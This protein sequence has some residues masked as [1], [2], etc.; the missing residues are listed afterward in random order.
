[1]NLE[2]SLQDSQHISKLSYNNESIR[3]FLSP[4]KLLSVLGECVLVVLRDPYTST[5]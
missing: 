5:Y 4:C 1:M 3:F 2:K